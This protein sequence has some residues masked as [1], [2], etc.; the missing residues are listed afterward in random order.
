MSK[1]KPLTDEEFVAFSLSPRTLEFI[2]DYRIGNGLK[3][4]DMNILDWGCGRGRSVLWLREQGYNAFGLDVGEEVI[5]NGLQLFRV[6]GY[7]DS[8][9]RL[10]MPDGRADFQDNYFHYT[11][12]NQVFEH[13]R[14]IDSVAGEIARVTKVG[15]IGFHVYPSHRRIVEGHLYMPFVHWMPK[16]VMRKYL[17]ALYVLVGIEPKWQFLSGA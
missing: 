9:L 13:V 12:S 5:N 2:E 11:F 10:L 8:V 1:I 6:K 14:D 3:K 4:E 7:T 17:V 15:G 16:N